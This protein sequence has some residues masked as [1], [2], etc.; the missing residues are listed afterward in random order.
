VLSDQLT[1]SPLAQPGCSIQPT[2]PT[3]APAPS[4]NHPP[5]PVFVSQPSSSPGV[6]ISTILQ[7]RCLYLNPSVFEL[8][9]LP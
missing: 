5:V 2:Q 3:T 7:S 9:H 1:N 4:T 6:C 8:T